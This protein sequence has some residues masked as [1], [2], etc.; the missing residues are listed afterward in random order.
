MT[1]LGQP[2][3]HQDRGRLPEPAILQDPASAAGIC[4]A[5]EVEVGAGSR[6]EAAE[7][8]NVSRAT[9]DRKLKGYGLF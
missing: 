5:V 4:S 2:E 1:A 7:M 3:V 9:I 8:L 6:K